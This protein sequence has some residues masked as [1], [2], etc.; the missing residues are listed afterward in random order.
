MNTLAQANG[1]SE[2]QFEILVDQAA[3]RTGADVSS[4]ENTASGTALGRRAEWAGVVAR[5]P[6]IISWSGDPHPVGPLGGPGPRTIDLAVVNSTRIFK[7][8]AVV[9]GGELGS[10]RCTAARASQRIPGPTGPLLLPEPIAV[11]PRGS[12]QP[13]R[14]GRQRN[15]LSGVSSRRCWSADPRPCAMTM[16]GCPPVDRVAAATDRSL[17][18]PPP[19]RVRSKHLT[20]HP[21]LPVELDAVGSSPDVR[22]RVGC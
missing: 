18:Q 9:I 12:G 1:T 4:V 13:H 5:G 8:Q 3:L 21:V 20:G 17:L 16:T 2:T 19:R 7:P 22:D 11:C 14:H 10:G 15:M 6:D